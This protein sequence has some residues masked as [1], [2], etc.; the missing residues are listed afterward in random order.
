MNRPWEVIRYVKATLG[1]CG[2][3]CLSLVAAIIFVGVFVLLAEA[4]AASV[5]EALRSPVNIVRVAVLTAAIWIWAY[6]AR[7]IRSVRDEQRERA[8]S[9]G[10]RP[11]ADLGFDGILRDTR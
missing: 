8:D 10:E 1:E 6:I 11:L 3:A 2:W 9:G 7:A 4:P 5:W